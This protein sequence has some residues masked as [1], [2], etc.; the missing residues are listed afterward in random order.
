VEYYTI[1][2]G[3]KW[4]SQS[5]KNLSTL[6]IIGG[7]KRNWI[8]LKCTSSQLSISV[9]KKYKKHGD[10]GTPKYINFSLTC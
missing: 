4:Q 6:V 8:Y 9:N 1:P 7:T 3:K 5:G 2:L 10:N